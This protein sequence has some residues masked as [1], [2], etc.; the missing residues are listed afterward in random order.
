MIVLQ[1]QKI[2]VSTDF[3]IELKTPFFKT[4]TFEGSKRTLFL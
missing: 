3:F 1:N 4:L 2:P